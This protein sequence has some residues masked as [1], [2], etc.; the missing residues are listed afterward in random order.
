VPTLAHPSA[1]IRSIAEKPQYR[2]PGFSV[3][4]NSSSETVRKVL[5]G[6]KPRTYARTKWGKKTLFSRP[7]LA[8]SVVE[9]PL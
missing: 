4:G 2:K 1:L 7:A 5:I 3:S 9:T 6:S 8:K